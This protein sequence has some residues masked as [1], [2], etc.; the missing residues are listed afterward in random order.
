MG[1]RFPSVKL[2]DYAGISHD[3]ENSE[4]QFAAVVLAHLKARETRRDMQARHAWKVR[5]VKG[6]YE[7]GW[8]AAGARKTCASSFG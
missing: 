3:L 2:L 7:R 1:I 4:N 8:S 6:L 5:L